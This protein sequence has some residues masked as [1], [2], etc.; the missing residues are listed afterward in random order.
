[1]FSKRYMPVPGRGTYRSSHLL[2]SH[3]FLRCAEVVTRCAPEAALEQHDG[4]EERQSE[5]QQENSE[6]EAALHV[7]P[8]TYTSLHLGGGLGKLLLSES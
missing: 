5:L 2:I 8:R 7:D 3:S 4:D 6:L 1:M